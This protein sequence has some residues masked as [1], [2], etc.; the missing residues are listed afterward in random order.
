MSKRC[1]DLPRRVARVTWG[2]APDWLPST[3]PFGCFG[4]SSIAWAPSGRSPSAALVVGAAAPSLHRHGL[5]L[6]FPSFFL[7]PLRFMSTGG[8]GR[9]GREG[10]PR[11]DSGPTR[12]GTPPEGGRVWPRETEGGGAPLPLPPALP[13]PL[14]CAV[15][16]CHRLP[17]SGPGRDD[18]AGPPALCIW[19]LHCAGGGQP[20]ASGSPFPGSSSGR[21]AAFGGGP[22]ASPSPPTVLTCPHAARPVH[23]AP[24]SSPADPP[25]PSSL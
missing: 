11:D 6:S 18:R 9:G 17:L 13:R 16:P 21:A 1:R 19:R 22:N 24:L 15:Q 4:G 10:I 23:P 20:R 12:E 8:T 3:P 14:P 2:F 25:S 7:L 5:F